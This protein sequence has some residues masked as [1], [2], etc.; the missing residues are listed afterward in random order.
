[1]IRAMTAPL[2]WAADRLA[3]IGYGTR[4][5]LRLCGLGA[6]SVRRLRL[7]VDQMHFIGNY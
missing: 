7:V 5:F 2:R 4:F 1:M 3:L 6:A